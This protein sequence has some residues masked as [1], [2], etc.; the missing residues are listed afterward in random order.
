MTIQK[1]RT[2][3]HCASWWIY[4]TPSLRGSGPHPPQTEPE[5]DQA[6]GSNDQLNGNRGDK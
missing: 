5:S 6:C 4:T 2:T 3:K 1:K